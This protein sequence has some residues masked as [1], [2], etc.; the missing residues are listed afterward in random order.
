MPSVTCTNCGA[1]LKTKDP[2]PAGKK[3]KC[4]KCAQPF[5]VKAEEEEL[6]AEP[7]AAASE[8]KGD[9][10]AEG[11]NDFAG[12]GDDGDEKPKKGKSGEKP[13]KSKTGLIIGIVAGVLLLCCCGPTCVYGI[14]NLG[15]IA[16]AI[17]LSEASKRPPGMSDEDWNAKLIQDAINKSKKK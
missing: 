5:V 17:G 10:A 6:P 15:A 1:V 3:V 8:E 13:K 16:A 4:P 12:I 11:G 14:I 7:A 9:D 2:V